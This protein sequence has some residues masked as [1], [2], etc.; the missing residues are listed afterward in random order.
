MDKQPLV[1][2]PTW[3]LPTCTQSP[4]PAASFPISSKP[5]SFFWG[6]AFLSFKTSLPIKSSSLVFNGTAKPIP[7]SKGSCWPS[8]SFPN[9]IKPAS[10]LSL[11]KAAN[12][13]GIKPSFFPA[14]ISLSQTSEACFGWH[15]TS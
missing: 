15:H 5:T 2:T 8:N 14:S 13:A 3:D 12:P 4:C 7:A 10:I 6:F 1:I 9:K 11:S